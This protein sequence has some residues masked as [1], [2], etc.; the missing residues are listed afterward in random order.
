MV[1]ELK[2]KVIIM[3]ISSFFRKKEIISRSKVVPIRP[4]IVSDGTEVFSLDRMEKMKW[5]A[6]AIV[7]GIF[8]IILSIIFII[9]LW[10]RL[11]LKL[12]L[13]C[14]SIMALLG[15]L[16]CL[17]IFSDHSMVTGFFTIGLIST[18]L[19]WIYDAL[20]KRLSL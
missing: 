15:V 6:L 2:K 13:G 20:L 19:S 9:M 12:L 8:N 17:T 5:V 1:S 11:P 16:L 18:A 3:K 7:K 14:I 10:L 4:G